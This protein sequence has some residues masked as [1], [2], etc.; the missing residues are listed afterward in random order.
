MIL[1]LDRLYLDSKVGELKQVF[2]TILDMTPTTTK[3]N[4]KI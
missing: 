2:D 3:K 1:T 4:L